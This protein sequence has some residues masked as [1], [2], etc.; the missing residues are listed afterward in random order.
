MSVNSHAH[1]PFPKVAG[2]AWRAVRTA[3]SARGWAETLAVA[4]VVG[5]IGYAVGRRTGL[6]QPAPGRPRLGDALTILVVPALGEELLF[7]AALTPSRAETPGD[8]RAIGA[9]TLAFTAWH[10][11]EAL[12]FLPGARRTFLRSDFLA[13]CALEGLACAWLLRRTGS[14]WPGVVLHW[15]EVFVWKTWLGGAALK[16][17][18]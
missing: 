8:L 4:G 15:A 5:A 7:R 11:L 2:R 10:V 17:R 1:G 12:T 9:S 13:L 14:V 6:F 16:G 18:V 3:P